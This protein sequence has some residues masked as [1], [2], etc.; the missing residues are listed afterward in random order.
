M[1]VRLLVEYAIVAVLL[2][3]GG[4]AITNWVKASVQE[5]KVENLTT[6][7]SHAEQRLDTAETVNATQETVILE[8]ADQRKVDGERIVELIDT[9]SQLSKADK[10]LRNKLKDLEKKDDAKKYLDTPVPDSVGCLYDDSCPP[11]A[12][13]TDEGDQGNASRASAPAVRSNPAPP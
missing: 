1:N 9:Y 3:V 2:A 12:G 7:L 8:L 4:V 5:Q 13:G 11:P 10:V 6:K